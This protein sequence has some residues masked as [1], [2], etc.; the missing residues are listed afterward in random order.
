LRLNT[1]TK[2]QPRHSISAITPMLSAHTIRRAD[3]ADLAGIHALLDHLDA[4]H[5][6]QLPWL[7]KKSDESRSPAYLNAF[8]S[9]ADKAAFVALGPAIVGLVLAY[10]RELP[11]D[12]VIQPG[13][14]AEIETL[15]VHPSCRRRGL[16]RALIETAMAW[17]GNM[18]AARVELGVYEFNTVAQSFWQSLG[19]ETLSRRLHRSAP[20]AGPES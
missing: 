11:A 5:V 4:L 3:K 12:P 16:G 17:C 1:T 19:F 9:D 18:G 10:I 7:L 20:V 15:I 14:I 6:A 8:L 13:R 2:N